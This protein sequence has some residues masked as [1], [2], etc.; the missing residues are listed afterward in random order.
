M[1]PEELQLRLDNAIRA[2]DALQD[3]WNDSGRR[4][5]Q[6]GRIYKMALEYELRLR[7]R[8]GRTAAGTLPGG[9]K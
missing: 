9:T 2:V 4:D 6:I 7:G 3:A 5:R 8:I 1:T